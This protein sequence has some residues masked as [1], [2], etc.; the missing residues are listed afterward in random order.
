VG[1]GRRLSLSEEVTLNIVRY[2]MRTKDLKTFHRIAKVFLIK[3]FPGIPN[4]ENFQKATN[5][6]LPFILILFR[7]LAERKSKGGVYF[8]D[9]TD[10]SVCKNH[11]IHTHKVFKGLAGRGKTCSASDGIG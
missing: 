5:R 9:S 8:V 4:Y 6:S 10:L 1:L 3:Y 11:N 2:I 7:Y